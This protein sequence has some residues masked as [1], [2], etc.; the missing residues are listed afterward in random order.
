MSTRTYMNIKGQGN[1]FT[2]LQRHSDSTFSNLFSLE[3]PW[4]IKAKF[5]VEPPG[6]GGMIACSNGLGHMTSIA[7][8]PIYSKQKT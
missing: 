6:D 3:T 7:A 2:L 1:S 5:Y 8:M 4:L